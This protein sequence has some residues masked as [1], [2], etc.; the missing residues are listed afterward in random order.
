VEIA[1]YKEKE[2][3]E[4]SDRREALLGGKVPSVPVKAG[5]R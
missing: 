4:L 2:E 3:W 1:L 5:G